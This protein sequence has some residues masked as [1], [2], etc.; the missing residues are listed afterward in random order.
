MGNRWQSLG[1]RKGKEGTRIF[2]QKAVYLVYLLSII[3]IET[4][5]FLLRIL[6]ITS[7][8]FIIR[9]LGTGARRRDLGLA[10]ML[11][12]TLTQHFTWNSA[13]GVIYR[14]NEQLAYG[15]NKKETSL[16]GGL[17]FTALCPCLYGFFTSDGFTL[18]SKEQIWDYIII[19]IIIIKNHLEL[20]HH[21]FL[22]SFKII[23]YLNTNAFLFRKSEFTPASDG[24]SSC[25]D[26][27][28]NR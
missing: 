6:N 7:F 24:R 18:S 3:F 10:G 12:W 9:S 2:T 5:H 26:S 28:T 16:Q 22:A 11:R 27:D 23:A 20:Y 13:L 1:V 14:L 15:L 25:L 4:F 19:I 8:V 21:V 17:R